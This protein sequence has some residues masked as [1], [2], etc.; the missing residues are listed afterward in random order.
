[1]KSKWIIVGFALA[2]TRPTV[3]QET[4]AV[5]AT[6]FSAFRVISQR[7]IFDPNRAPR[8]RGD[9]RANSSRPQA[10]DAF[11]LVGILSYA[12]GDFAFFDGTQSEYRKILEPSGQIA[13][14]T[15]AEITPSVV[16]LTND[17]RLVEMRVGAQLRRD[18]ANGWPLV[19]SAPAPDAAAAE[20][21]APAAAE[22]PAATTAAS[23]PNEVLRRLM[24]QREQEL[25]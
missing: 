12:K 17:H 24:Q 23:E 11:S 15:V 25:K 10:A 13:G 7:N 5:S 2:T 6:D 9:G 8:R 20:T 3:A 18:D 1:M 21:A 16:K 22:P 4:N 14:Y 19:A